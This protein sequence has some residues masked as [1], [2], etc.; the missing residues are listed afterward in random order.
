[1]LKFIG[2]GIALAVGAGAF[3][4]WWTHEHGD[5]DLANEM[6]EAGDYVR[7]QG[8]KAQDKIEDI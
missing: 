8:D 1:M 2:S 6:D 3:Y 5:V 7:E 4:Y